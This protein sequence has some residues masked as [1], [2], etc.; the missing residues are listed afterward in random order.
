MTGGTDRG[1]TDMQSPLDCT[2]EA[3][4]GGLH[5]IGEDVMEIK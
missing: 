2:G 5:V 3:Q 4:Q 1:E